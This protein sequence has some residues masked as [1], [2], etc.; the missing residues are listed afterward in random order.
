MDWEKRARAIV[1]EYAG[2]PSSARLVNDQT[3][4]VL[5]FSH[6]MADARTAEIFEAIELEFPRAG[7]KIAR[8]FM[9]QPKTREQTLEEALN[10]LHRM[11]LD[12][13][14]RDNSGEGRAVALRALGA[15]YKPE[16]SAPYWTEQPP[17]GATIIEGGALR[18]SHWLNP[19]THRRIFRSDGA[20]CDVPLPETATEVMMAEEDDRRRRYFESIERRLAA[21]EKQTPEREDE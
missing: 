11:M 6:E 18:E 5:S 1:V 2:A 13:H 15:S 3:K 10:V 21:L 19:G 7:E 12:R 20:F 16:P 4:E 14:I 8:L 17:E 9:Q